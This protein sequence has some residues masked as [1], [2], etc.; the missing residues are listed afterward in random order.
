M[1]ALYS[2]A[3]ALLVTLRRDPVFAMTIPA[4]IQSYLASGK[5]IVGALDG[6]GARTIRASGAGLVA[7]AQDA[8]GLAQ[9][10]LKIAALSVAERDAMGRRGREYFDQYFSRDKLIAQLES[11]M[12]ELVG[13]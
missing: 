11:W 12:R 6:E 2:R 7:E 3:D 1:P 4:K 10:V 8:K 9:C 13:I 5:V